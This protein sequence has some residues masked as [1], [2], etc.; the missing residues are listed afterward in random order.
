LVNTLIIK[1][2]EERGTFVIE[3]ILDSEKD[4]EFVER[5]AD[6]KY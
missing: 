1:T 4:I 2:E 6:K 3:E 5:K